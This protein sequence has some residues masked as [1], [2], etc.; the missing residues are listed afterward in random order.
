MLLLNEGTILEHKRDFPL[1]SSVTLALESGLIMCEVADAGVRAVAPS[2]GSATERVLGPLVNSTFAQADI[3][4]Q[5]AKVVPS[6]AP[7]TVTL[8]NTPL[9]A[10]YRIVTSAGTVLADTTDYSVSGNVVTFILAGPGALAGGESVTISYR[11]A[12][13]TGLLAARFGTRSVNNNPEGAHRQVTVG[14]GQCDVLLSNFDTSQAYAAVTGVV[15]TA[16]NG[17]FTTSASGSPQ[18]FGRVT[19]APTMRLNNGLEQ[20]YVGVGFNTMLAA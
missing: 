16:A 11:Y 18:I 7:L 17:R 3:S 12:I 9:A 5:E 13:S 4:T 2:T 6:A 8:L 1:A 19:S 14:Y 20:L 15:R 10:S